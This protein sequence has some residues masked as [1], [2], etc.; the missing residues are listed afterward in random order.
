M[1]GIKEL[2]ER[3]TLLEMENKRLTDKLILVG[4]LLNDKL[5]IKPQ[6]GST[7]FVLFGDPSYE[8]LRDKYREPKQIQHY[9]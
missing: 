8:E 6:S 7:S 2:K 9:L 3:V 1:F 5:I 4:E